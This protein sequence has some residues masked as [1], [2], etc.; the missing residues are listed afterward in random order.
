MHLL[1]GMPRDQVNDEA[2][3]HDSASLGYSCI[4]II[5]IED[6]IDT[7]ISFRTVK[8]DVP[9]FYAWNNM[10]GCFAG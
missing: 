5:H 1:S 9:I 3:L 8:K 2:T 10:Q 4:A 7:A 6:L